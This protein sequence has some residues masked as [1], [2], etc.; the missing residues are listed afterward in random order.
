MPVL[1]RGIIAVVLL[2]C[3]ALGGVARAADSSEV[4]PELKGYVPLNERTRLFLDG[5]YTEGTE[6][7]TRSVDVGAFLDVSLKPIRRR[8]LL[9]EDWQRSRYLW[10]RIGYSRLFDVTD[11]SGR[12]N[13]E[14][15]G[16]VSILG[17]VPL[18]ADTWLEARARADLRW[19][20]SD[21]STRYRLRLEA[22]RVFTLLRRPLV[23]KASVEWYYDTRY[24]GW[25]SVLYKLGPEF[26]INKRFRFEVYLGR[27]NNRLPSK[28]S[29]NI[30]GLMVSGYY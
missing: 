16:V 14:N 17:K 12:Q 25:S 27:Q 15:R 18:P 5:N 4:W 28:D 19:I 6:S 1:V 7:D 3:A 30:L 29:V 10:A 22:T 8:V 23:P 11:D 21:Y 24:D 26:T 9:H 13:T 20:G 2:G